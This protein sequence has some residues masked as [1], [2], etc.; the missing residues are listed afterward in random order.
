MCPPVRLIAWLSGSGA[1]K[2]GAETPR[3]RRHVLGVAAQAARCSNAM[4]AINGSPTRGQPRGRAEVRPSGRGRRPAGAIRGTKRRMLRG[5]QC[6]ERSDANGG[7]SA[8]S[9]GECTRSVGTTS[10][11]THSARAART[12]VVS[13]S[14][15][16]EGTATARAAVPWGAYEAPT[17]SMSGLAFASSSPTVMSC[18]RIT[19]SSNSAGW[20]PSPVR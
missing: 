19:S 16:G 15:R 5:V 7:G 13:L 10:G 3:R 12:R 2:V 1:H 20:Y 9:A 8:L 11:G 4:R 6:A 17:R 18:S 14:L